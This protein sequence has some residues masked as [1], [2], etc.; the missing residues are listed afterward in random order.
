MP[1]RIPPPRLPGSTGVP[2]P[3]D[4]P[5][6]P[7]SDETRSWRTVDFDPAVHGFAFP[8]A[9]VDEHLTLP[10]GATITTRGRCGG[11]SYA[12]LDY[13]LSGR[14]V[15]RWSAVLYAP[16]RVPPDDH[17][18]AR[19]LQERQ[20]QSFMTG[21]AAKF[22]TWT[23][24]SDDETW[25]F[26]GVSRWTKEEEVPRVVA[27]VD[28]GRPVV[29]GLVVARSLGKVGQNHQVVA[30][31]YD[32]DRVSGRTVLRVYDPNTPGR[33]V[34]LVSD[35]DHKDWTA[36]NGA[37][38]RGFFVQDYTPKPPRVLTRTAPAPDL[39]VRTGDVLKLSHVWTGRTLHSH[40]LAYT[41][42]GT[43]GQQQVTAFDGS[44]DNDLWRLEGPHGTAAGEGD[45][46]A[47]RDGDVVRLRHVATGRRLH[48]HRGFPSPVSGQQ[49]VTA[50]G[51]DDTG[52]ANDDWRVE[53]DGGGRWRA[54]GR[55]RLVHVATGVALH[56]HR[57]AH[58]QHT[59]G[60]QEVTGYD[61]RD[62]NDWW[63]VL[64]VR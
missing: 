34:Q 64:E 61:G 53:S 14:P 50:F 12:T 17:W 43:S 1:N 54:G 23:L 7:R 24:H 42:D 51:G 52:D 44:D 27:A 15:P 41:H 49:E 13:F 46:R 3:W 38:W 2:G 28:A 26:K 22:L 6:P 19:Y 11:M 47:L 9:F 56:S 25:V 18:L 33:E 39:Q 37:R 30:Y 21:S 62:D 8:N 10:N 20:V 31:G 57:A 45:G 32:L 36:T 5:V 16:G 48:S 63:S 4:A 58:Q 29:L 40:A 55:V 60:Q 59:A 35:E